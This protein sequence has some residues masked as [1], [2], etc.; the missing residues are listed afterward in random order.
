VKLVLTIL[1]IPLLAAAEER[2]LDAV[3]TLAMRDIPAEARSIQVWIPMPRD[4][5]R[6]VLAEYLV[7]GGLP[8]TVREVAGGNRLLHVDFS[9][10]NGSDSL[11]VLFRV[12]RWGQPRARPAS[13]AAS[14]FRPYLARLMPPDRRIM[15]PELSERAGL[16]QVRSVFARLAG[17]EGAELVRTLSDSDR[18]HALHARFVAELRELGLAA[19]LVSGLVLPERGIS[20]TF[21]GPRFW[22]EY[23]QSPG[24]WVL[25]DLL[26]GE[27]GDPAGER[28][29]LAAE[30][31]DPPPAEFG[32]PSEI[33]GKPLV[34]IDGIVHDD[35]EAAWS[36]RD[37]RR[38]PVRL[39][40]INRTAYGRIN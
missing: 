13:A 3:F 5:D 38:D 40:L 25:V 36:G 11:S 26:A 16:E 35:V 6:Q 27:M 28:I 7:Q 2:S 1:L 33:W 17:P 12:E 10:G 15:E 31:A 32:E 37:A 18:A 24:D 14:G 20:W 4:D 34:V 30:P 22:A 23:S 8:A 29:V 39:V 21:A 9:E 19:R